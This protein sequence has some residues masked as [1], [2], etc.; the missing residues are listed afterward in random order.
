MPIAIKD[1]DRGLS[2]ERLRDL[3]EYDPA[4]GAFT[5][6]TSR[7][8]S[9]AGA[10]AGSVRSSGHREVSIDGHRYRTNRLAWFY[11]TNTWP[12]ELIDHRNRDPGDDRWT[13]LRRATNQQNS[14]NGLRKPGASGVVGVRPAGNGKFRSEIRVAGGRKHLGTF[15]TMNDAVAA[16]AA[17]KARHHPYSNG[18][19]Q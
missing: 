4:S 2:R 15:A 1:R 19:F 11:M 13:N 7:G 16:Y 10:R 14:H 18:D 12:D 3:L 17:A 5:W 9:P 8:R 6:L